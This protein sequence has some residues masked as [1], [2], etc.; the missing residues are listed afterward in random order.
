MLVSFCGC[1][2]VTPAV[3]QQCE[4]IPGVRMLWRAL[5]HLPELSFGLFRL[6]LIQ[7]QC[8]AVPQIG[9]FLILFQRFSEMVQNVF[10]SIGELFEQEF[11]HLQVG[12]REFR[13]DLEGGFV[14]IQRTSVISLHLRNFGQ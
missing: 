1:A 4:V 9:I 6:I 5:Y 7:Q 11:C 2:E 10:L 8:V 12:A 13:V 3:R 14:A